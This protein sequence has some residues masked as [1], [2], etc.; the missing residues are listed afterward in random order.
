M[1]LFSVGRSSVNA[2]KIWQKKKRKKFWKNVIFFREKKHKEKQERFIDQYKEPLYCKK[3]G[4]NSEFEFLQEKDV[5]FNN[6]TSKATDVTLANVFDD[7]NINLKNLGSIEKRDF[8]ELLVLEKLLNEKKY[9]LD[10]LS[11]FGLGKIYD[12]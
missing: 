8:G 7:Y 9:N 5:I 12:L 6:L 10:N 1:G 11:R 3:L 2:K 4:F